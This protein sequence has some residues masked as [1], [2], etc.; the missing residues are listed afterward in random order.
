MSRWRETIGH[1]FG[2]G[3][4][5]GSSKTTDVRNASGEVGGQ[6]IEHWDGSVDAHITPETVRYTFG[7]KAF[8]PVPEAEA[9]KYRKK[10]GA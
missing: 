8:E 5:A 7:G 4:H 10:H 3:R 1:G 9:K 2:T 6:Q